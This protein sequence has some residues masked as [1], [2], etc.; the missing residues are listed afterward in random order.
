MLF[1]R[2]S[3]RLGWKKTK[4]EMP[5]GGKSTENLTTNLYYC[6]G[7]SECNQ[8]DCEHY[9]LHEKISQ[10]ELPCNFSDESNA[11]CVPYE[12]NKKMKE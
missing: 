8:L 7:S 5:S 3:E 11:S 1:Q 10:C 12:V 9:M 4:R 2:I 6:K